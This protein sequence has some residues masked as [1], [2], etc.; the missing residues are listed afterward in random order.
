M[1]NN[2]AYEQLMSFQRQTEALGLVAERLGWDQETMMP[3]G[4]AEQRSEEMAA[5]E[6][7]LHTR[8]TDGRIADWL[9]AADPADEEG[10]AQLRLLRRS[11]VR[12][13][14]VPGD[15]AQELARVISMAQGIWAEARANDKVADFLPTLQEV[16]GLKR[17]EAA[18]L[19]QGGDRYDALLDDYEPG[20]TAES[21]AAMF[22]RMRPRLVAL[23]EAVL[24]KP[25][26][27][28]LT[29]RFGEAAQM[30]LAR[31]LGS[32]FGFDWSRGRL[33]LAVH[34]FSSGSAYDSRITTRVVESEPFNC[35]Y[36]T[37]GEVIA[38]RCRQIP[39]QPQLRRLAEMP[40]H[41]LRHRF[42]QHRRA[43][44]HQP[45]P[46]P[47]EHRRQRLRRR[48]RFVIVDQCVVQ[49]AALRQTRRLL[50]L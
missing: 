36:S 41:S 8:R 1:T 4:A 43:Q 30:R 11:F 31:D 27:A 21:V 40:L 34:P 15:L 3:R 26:P 9:E 5:M 24:A 49:I 48:P 2:V 38:K 22:G 33:D 45:G 17:Q 50:P 35:I 10:R 7:V 46:H 44:S 6:G 14:K 32:A 28:A 19:A 29:G 13:S 37:P 25:A 39:R 23:R 42:P 12:A 20:M 47:P 16:I 18:C